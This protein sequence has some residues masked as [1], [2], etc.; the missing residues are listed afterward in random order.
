MS[1]IDEE[2]AADKAR[3][4]AL[5]DQAKL[6]DEELKQLQTWRTRAFDVQGR[7]LS[8]LLASALVSFGEV[9]SQVNEFDDKLLLWYRETKCRKTFRIMLSPSKNKQRKLDNASLWENAIAT[10]TDAIRTALFNLESRFKGLEEMLKTSY[11]KC[12]AFQDKLETFSTTCV[13]AA[14][15]EAQALLKHYQAKSDAHQLVLDDCTAEMDEAD[16]SLRVAKNC[17]KKVEESRQAAEKKA[18]ILG[19]VGT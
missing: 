10:M 17:H 16:M 19:G 15:R 6:L 14:I 5:C 11:Q 7:E 8:T 18:K 13:G 9:L 4:E 3:Y 12:E 2:N 1:S